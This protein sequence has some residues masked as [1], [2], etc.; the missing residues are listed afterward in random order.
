MEKQSIFN[1][2]FEIQKDTQFC[3]AIP[4]VLGQQRKLHI[5][6]VLCLFM[7]VAIGS[8]CVCVGACMLIT[9]CAISLYL[10]HG[11]DK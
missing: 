1:E 4:T 6:M 2:N 9:M 8:L 7:T 3:S 5:C 10:R 11:D